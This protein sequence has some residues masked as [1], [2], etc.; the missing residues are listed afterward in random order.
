[1]QTH[2]K[3]LAESHHLSKSCIHCDR[4][5]SRLEKNKTVLEDVRTLFTEAVS[6]N[7]Q[8]APAGDWLLDNFYL[9]EDHI[10]TSKRDLPK[11]YNRELPRLQNRTS[12]GLPR[13]YDI[14]LERISHGDGRVDPETLP[15]FINAYQS[16]S[17]LTLGE[18]WAIP[19]MLRLALVENL[20]RVAIRIA[21]EMYTQKNAAVWADRMI[22]MAESEPK[23][24]ILLVADMARSEQ[25]MVSSF[26]AE[27]ARRLQGKGAALALPLMLIEQWLSKTGLTIELL[28]QSEIQQQAADQVSVSNTI[29]SLRSLGA[30]D[31]KKFVESTSV[32][33]KIL[34]EDPSGYYGKMDFMTRDQYRHVIEKTAKRSGLTEQAV[35]LNAIQL[36]QKQKQKTGV[37]ERVSHVGFYLLDKGFVL[38]RRMSH[39]RLTPAEIF[40]NLG[41]SGNLV[42]Y[43]GSV[44]SLAVICA[45]ELTAGAHYSG[46]SGWALV[47][48][49]LLSF[50]C[51]C[52]LS[53]ALVNWL[54]TVSSLPHLLPRMDFSDGIPPESRTLVVIPAMLSSLSHVEHLIEDM[55]VRFLANRDDNLFFGLLTDF[56]DAEEEV[57]PSDAELVAYAQQKIEELNNL[58]RNPQ[59][60]PL[61]L[62]HRGRKWNACESSWMGYER[63]R[64]KLAD[65]N[66]LLRDGERDPFELIVGKT[67]HLTSVKYVITLDTDT[68]LSRDTARELI[69]TMAHPL[70][71][72]RYDEKRSRVVEGYGILQPRV[73]ASL[74]AAYRSLYAWLN[75]SD[76]GLDPY[77]RAVSNVYQDLFGEG[78]YI[79]KGIYDVE[80]FELAL[81][82]R[83]PENRILSHDL[84]E[85]CY[86]RAGLVSDIQLFEEVPLTYRSDTDRR[87]RWIRGDWQLLRWLFP[88]VP[89][90]GG[91]TH[92]NVLS[93]L[94]KW[95]ILDNLRRSVTSAALTIL[96]VIGWTFLCNPL[97]WTLSIAGIVFVSPILASLFAYFQKPNDMPLGS[98]IASMSRS[99]LINVSPIVLTIACLPYD[100]YFSL[101]AI[102]RTCWRMVFT[103]RN[104]LEWQPSNV[105]EQSG[106]MNL[107]S[108]FRSMWIAPSLASAI[109]LF[110][111]LLQSVSVLAASPIL[112]FWFISP[113]L[114]WWISRPLSGRKKIMTEDQNIFL[115]RLSR[116]TWAFFE[117]F[118]TAEENWLPPDNFQEIPAAKISHRTSPTN[119]GLALLANLGARDLG[120]I[121]DGCLLERTIL[122]LQSMAALKKHRKHFYNWYDTITMQPLLPR[123]VSTVDSGNLASHLLTLRSGLLALPDEKI[124][125]ATIWEG[126][127]DTQMILGEVLEDKQPA[128]FIQFRKELEAV[129]SFAPNT[130][131][132]VWTSLEQLF[133]SAEEVY[134]VLAHR[135][136]PLVKW[137][138]KALKRQCRDSLDELEFLM[139]WISQDQLYKSEPDFLRVNSFLSLRELFVFESEMIQTFA[140]RLPELAQ[141]LSDGQTHA[142]ERFSSINKAALQIEKFTQMDFVFLYNKHRHLFS[143]GHKVD[144]RRK[145]PGYYDL[146][147]SEARMASFIA[148]A[149]G[150][151]PQEN[152]FSLRRFLVKSGSESLLLSWSGSMFE[153]LMPLLVMPT[154]RGTLLDQTC[155]VAVRRQIEYGRQ[156]NI[157]W[158]ISESGYN[159]YDVSL[160]YQYRAFGVP[161]MGLMR[162]L[163]EDLVVAPYATALSLMVMP[164]KACL[165]LQRLSDSGF[166]GDYGLY[167]AID[168]TKSRVQS[169]KSYTI[170][171]SFMAHHQGMSFLSFV[172]HLL[173]K[174]MQ[175]RFELIPIIRATAL[176]LEEKIPR[177]TFS[178]SQS[179]NIPERLTSHGVSAMPV[180]VF[181]S[182]DTPVPEVQLLSNGN[183]HVMVT[184]AGGGYSRWKELALTRWH[185]DTTRD[186]WGTFVYIRD[187][188]TKEFW[189]NAYQPTLKHPENYEVVFSEGR[190]EFRRCD[191][192][193]DTYTEI[194]VSPEDDIELR[195]VRITNLT[196]YQRTIE[197]TSYT[198][199]VIAT[200]ASD[201]AHPD[202]S[203]LFI[204]TEIIEEKQA[205]L[206]TRRP[207]SPE[208]QFPCMLHLM[209]VRD[210]KV[211]A[212]SYETD[213]MQFIGRGNSIVSPKAMKDTGSLSGSQGSVLDPV[214]AIRQK[215]VIEPE[216][217]VTIDLVTGISDT[218]ES[219]LHLVEKYLG[220]RFANRVFELSQTHSHLVLQQINATEADANLYNHLASAILYAHSRL[221]TEAHCI[222]ANHQG[223]S[224]L[225][226]YS[227]S[228]DLPIVLLRIED[229]ANIILVRQLVQAHSYW[230]QKGLGV[231]LVIWNEEYGTYRQQLQEQILGIVTAGS[232]R[233]V[234]NRP[235][236]IFVRSVDQIST[237]DRL[238]IQAVSRI[239]L[240]DSHG[241]LEDQIEGQSIQKKLIPYLLS[242]R[243][244]KPRF[245]AT[246]LAARDLLFFNGLGGFSPDGHEYV[247][248]TGSSQVTP[249]P[250][251]NV[252]ANPHFG[253]VVSE[254]GMSYT[255]S[256]NAH[257]FR[258][259][260]WYNDPVSDVS[261]E[262]LYIRDE[263]SGEFWSPTL[264]PRCGKEPY[265]SR[266]G[267]GYSVFEHS[268]LGIH[269]ELCVFVALAAPVKFM[270]L[271]I[272]NDSGRSRRLST[273]AYAELV[274]G[275]L[276]AK[277]SMHVVTEVDSG[278]GAL[279]AR[280][281]HNT[282]FAGT[283]VFLDVTGDNRTV[284]GDRTEFIGRNGTLANPEA[285]T[286]VNL[287]GV[288]GPA[289]DPCAAIQVPFV[290]ANGKECEIVFKLGAGSNTDEASALVHRF[291]TTDSVREALDEVRSYWNHATSKVQLETP[292]ASLNVLANGW[293]VYQVL[294]CRL[295]GR[296]GFYQ[297]GGAFGYRDQLQDVMALVYTEPTIVREHILLCAA[298]Q[299]VEGDVQHWWHPPAGRGSRTHCSDDYLWLPLATCRYISITGDT[300]ILDDI[301][302]FIEGHQLNLYE[303]S[304]YNQPSQSEE[305]ASLYDHCVRSILYS[306]PR[307]AH[308]LPL[309]GSGD[310]ND[311]MNMV[312]KEGKGESVWLGFFLYTVLLQ[313]SEIALQHK[314]PAFA[315]RCLKEAH[316]LSRNIEKN[317][318]DDSWYRRAWFDDGSPL[319]S[320][321]NTECQID[322]IA[323]SWSVLS[324]AGEPERSRQA[325]KS[326]DDFLVNRE[327]DLIQLLEPPF[328]KSSPNPGYIKG[329]VPGV[330]ENGGQYTHAAIWAA[331]AFA[332]L[333]DNQ[334]AWELF[335]M[336]NPIN[337]SVSPEKIAVYKVDPYVMAADVYSLPPHTGRGGWTWYTGS[338]GWMYRLILESL[339][340]FDL[341]E[342]TV[343]FAPCLPPDWESFKIHYRFRETMYHI[344]VIQI[345]ASGEMQVCVDGIGQ[346]ENTITLADDH[347]EHRVELRIPLKKT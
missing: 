294:S 75:S 135:K 220:R 311:G 103:H 345:P 169:G 235:G 117:T 212:V 218:R 20:R 118:V 79:G 198:E 90:F 241:T 256:G 233:N 299:F 83:F 113:A 32:V 234:L 340:G 328:D 204:Q 279:F 62:F 46:L 115:R 61:F 26:V 163:V 140:G 246:E 119:M 267:F 60:D 316:E 42:L 70:N 199:V 303:E 334:R 31:W 128:V 40:R 261:G 247:I 290:L 156:R 206:C 76:S 126:I 323:Q 91:E 107:A 200:A 125:G 4:L 232:E 278:T 82:G 282:E 210:A 3:S 335:T 186:N 129:M 268:E 28:V 144:S 159:S 167:E 47:V 68:L 131:S 217:L 275:D 84:L 143:I 250:W 330:R 288:T 80:V 157:P 171:R 148:I 244:V 38:L 283:T 336:I 228:G 292:D 285:M 101:G 346:K 35:A 52:G 309:I 100:A 242:S 194:A 343:R 164:E 178:H 97:L 14:A 116:K 153:Y 331:M 165:N 177:T 196:Q 141:L 301:I 306:F 190:A 289:H 293:L 158:G 263:E 192:N 66:A 145:D 96:L 245:R 313:F 216:T 338:A 98:H 120:Y 122:T 151:I 99:L 168:Y 24:L 43:I 108:S 36:A 105:S 78:S 249:A 314:D 50:L 95:K 287:S 318:W 215:I 339:L 17:T 15:G 281:W 154:Y 6:A 175:K 329:Y 203:N 189:S 259:T 33:E 7:R 180:R 92:K 254:S 73:A 272:R 55:E 344:E 53:I 230:H 166:E 269:S 223:Q 104:L 173:G 146:L 253:T 307:G 41:H 310:W 251:S 86:A 64:G 347:A 65:L 152:W 181:K 18:L 162:G 327:Y 81:K 134:K 88:I 27:L 276:R 205:V 5:L 271:K 77:T 238:L 214:V 174:P 320:S 160:N 291:Q 109:L 191:H 213:R 127:K 193:F 321:S 284:T 136:E 25:L 298:H 240:R 63:K 248:T 147:A 111:I 161:G 149:Q 22:C 172:S 262:A 13:V 342:D 315:E 322:S 74:P 325:M 23:N 308:G 195:R 19:I 211:V 208:E 11:G 182:Y 54:V 29:R 332:K 219:A 337:H 231:D 260:P 265:V 1:M 239:V 326:L 304:S 302:P 69:G 312:G 277:S 16:V 112:F 236:G 123:Y 179:T 187:D 130:L 324:G 207:R 341:T 226:G 57:L 39:V 237:E 45:A 102:I 89:T 155:H 93:V 8:I 21:K 114:V 58:Y 150:Q 227:I 87:R 124:P 170:V 273:T 209:T 202:F 48:T 30:Y 243:D 184:N 257:E 300:G 258:L 333:G 137:W 37:D 56:L 138:A 295:W 255:W 34:R 274:L 49:G 221:R 305:T 94:S 67:A 319:G 201:A 317:A 225:W 280:S 51:T 59:C 142:R 176:L 106:H 188:R 270:I 297:S 222:I 72:A 133:S 121:T 229:P 71:R 224:D 139:P 252:I 9:I 266:H 197:V 2:G 286:R 185:E 296:S 44:V 110:L 85:G 132:A 264:L 12:S 183:Y 10:R